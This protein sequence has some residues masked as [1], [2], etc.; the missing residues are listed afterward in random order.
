MSSAKTEAPT[1]RR[2][3]ELRAEGQTPYSRALVSFAALLAGGAMVLQKAPRA[4]DRLATTLRVALRAPES[5]RLS[6]EPAL[7]EALAWL[8]YVAGSV[9]A[10]ACVAAVAAGGAQTGFLFAPKRIAPS[11]A[12]VRPFASWRE[13]VRAASL[14][15]GALSALQL[16]AGCAL[17][18]WAARRCV[19]LAERAPLGEGLGAAWAALSGPLVAL[20]GGWVG[21]GALAALA[22]ASAQRALFDRRHR[23]SKQDV[24]DEHKHT[25]GDPQHKARRAHAHRELLEETI[26][27][28]TRRTDV[29]VRNPTHVAVGLRYRTEEH[30]APK[31]TMVGRGARARTILRASR[32]QGVPDFADPATARALALLEVGDAVP[33]ALF[34]PIAVIYR[35]LDAEA[36]ARDGGA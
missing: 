27:E 20:W 10:A 23:M 29:V 7:Y 2:L 9:V 30:D 1:P 22:D 24:R 11:A 17:T 8:G 34:E 35:W 16:L 18:W 15:S 5:G 28:A 32:R 3:R 33:G 21:I 6:A 12:G 4:V 26:R 19:T 13:R 36:S 31:V 25:E 14:W